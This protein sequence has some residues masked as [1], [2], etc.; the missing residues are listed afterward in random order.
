MKLRFV[1]GDML[2]RL[3]DAVKDL[4]PEVLMTAS[5]EEGIKWQEM[6]SSHVSL[7]SVHLKPKAFDEL[8]STQPITIGVNMS[9]LSKILRCG[10]KTDSISWTVEETAKNV[11]VITTKGILASKGGRSGKFSLNLMEIERESFAVPEIDY[12]AHIFMQ[13]SAFQKAIKDLMPF[14]DDV[15]ITVTSEHIQFSVDGDHGK[16]SLTF[17]NIRHPKMTIA[18]FDCFRLAHQSIDD[19]PQQQ[20]QQQQQQVENESIIS[21]GSAYIFTGKEQL[22][23]LKF[24]MKFIAAFA[25]CS[26]LSPHIQISLEK[27]SPIHLQ[28]PLYRTAT[29]TKIE[30]K[31]DTMTTTSATTTTTTTTT[32]KKKSSESRKP[33]EP[34][35]QEDMVGA[36]VFF[37]ASKMDDVQ[38]QPTSS[39]SS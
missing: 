3:V 22:T 19:E 16:G 8:Q 37:L 14:G 39:S 35:T 26:S 25:T 32:R 9:A 34:N 29:E 31:K 10:S 17:H 38:P 7:V 15:I 13:S 36:V 2:R 12:G 5:V 20:Q 27:D 33:N 21:A 4:V 18:S 28:Y 6:D 1:D 23:Q 11:L 24:P 30:Q